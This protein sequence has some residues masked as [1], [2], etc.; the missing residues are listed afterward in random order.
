M[1]Y[2]TA[3]IEEKLRRWENYLQHFSL[4]DWDEL[5]DTG[6]RMVEV[7]PYIRRCLNYLPEGLKD[8]R[9]LTAAAVNNYV[10]L[11]AMPRPKA[12][13]YYRVHLAYLLMICT[14][15]Q[16]LSLAMIRRFLPCDLSEA[17]MRAR[18]DTYAARYSRLTVAFAR[19]GREIALPVLE[20]SS[21]D[22]AARALV[23]S[24]CVVS[25]FSRLL[26]EKLVLLEEENS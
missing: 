3:Y 13:R 10:R 1:S 19:T 9:L 7:V 20:G 12:R 8:E 4:P 11:R 6:L 23:E 5:P 14:L 18:Y 25:S 2:D 24:A 17:E 22:E 26:A 15:K 21:G 16:S